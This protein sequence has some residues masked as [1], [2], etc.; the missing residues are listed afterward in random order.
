MDFDCSKPLGDKL[1]LYLKDDLEEM[2]NELYDNGIIFEHQFDS[3]I[4]MV[5]KNNTS[6]IVKLLSEKTQLN[7]RQDYD[8][9]TKNCLFYDLNRYTRKEAINKSISYQESKYNY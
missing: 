5:C 9:Q 6:E 8:N 4:S 1:E 2:C 3:L 7:I